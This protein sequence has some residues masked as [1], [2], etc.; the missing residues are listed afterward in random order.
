ML[1]VCKDAS[2]VRYSSV[3]WL[4]SRGTFGAVS[5][6]NRRSELVQVRE[7]AASSGR[8][9]RGWLKSKLYTAALLVGASGTG[10]LLVRIN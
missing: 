7:Y 1:R 5:P 3:P 6:N 9:K 10:L 4:V 2:V 8:R